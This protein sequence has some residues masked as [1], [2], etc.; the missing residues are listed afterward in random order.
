MFDDQTRGRHALIAGGDDAEDGQQ[1]RSPDDGGDGCG[2]EGE[3]QH[4][5]GEGECHRQLRDEGGER[6]GPHLPPG[7]DALALLG[8][9]DP[10]GVGEG[11]GHGDGQDPRQDGGTGAGA[12]RQPYQEAEGGDD[13]GGEPEREADA[14]RVRERRH[15]DTPYR[16]RRPVDGAAAPRRAS[17][18]LPTPGAFRS[19]AGT[20]SRR[21]RTDRRTWQ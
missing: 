19:P 15:P 10:H 20:A 11:V 13:A 2:P 7:V 16:P 17:C 6:G 5:H 14:H 18:P 3:E 1:R 21:G 8:D 4:R 9:V 12:P